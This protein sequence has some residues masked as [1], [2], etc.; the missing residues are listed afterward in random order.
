MCRFG[1]GS[2][3]LSVPAR[4]RRN[5]EVS[6]VPGKIERAAELPAALDA[7]SCEADSRSTGDRGSAASG[8]RVLACCQLIRS[9]SYRDGTFYF[10]ESERGL[11]QAAVVF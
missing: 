6:A 7:T 2:Y 10:G 5:L 9:G 8:V 1:V 3:F 4:Q 11:A